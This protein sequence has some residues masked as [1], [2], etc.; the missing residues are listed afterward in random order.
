MKLQI[1]TPDKGIEVD[2]EIVFVEAETIDGQI[3]ILNGHIGLVTALKESGLIRYQIQENSP[4]RELSSFNAVLEVESKNNQETIVKVIAKELK[5][6]S[7]Q[8]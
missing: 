6:L 3:G 4:F 2:Q 5:H 1:F 7:N 8:V